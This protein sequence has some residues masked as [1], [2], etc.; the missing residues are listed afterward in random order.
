MHQNKWLLDKSPGDVFIDK[1]PDHVIQ[2]SEHV[3]PPFRVLLAP[4]TL[5]PG[6]FPATHRQGDHDVGV[7]TTDL[8]SREALH[9]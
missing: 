4:A 8:E 2:R 6:E 3:L 9:H 7:S 5:V 1:C